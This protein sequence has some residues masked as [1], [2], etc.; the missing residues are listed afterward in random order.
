MPHPLFLQVQHGNVYTTNSSVA[1][2]L[3]PPPPPVPWGFWDYAELIVGLFLFIW[4]LSILI[5]PKVALKHWHH[6]FANMQ[7]SSYDLYDKIVAEIR[8]RKITNVNMGYG[9]FFEAG[10]FSARRE[11]LCIQYKKFSL[12]V[13]CTSFGTGYYI[14]W[15]LGE[16]DPG[17]LSRIPIIKDLLGKN[18]DYQSYYQLDTA[19]LFQSGIHDAILKVI[20]DF[21]NEKGV[22]LLTEFERQPLFENAIFHRKN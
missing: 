8:N 13:C 21:S 6:H 12:D 9:K 1:V 19:T 20:D 17:F 22:R 4:L 11:Y 7:L 15:W 18:P 2:T 5:R 10:I 3:A 14:S 16:D